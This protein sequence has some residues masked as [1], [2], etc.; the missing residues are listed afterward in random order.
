M[1]VAN[2]EYGEDKFVVTFGGLRIE[3]A[4]WNMLGGYLADSGWTAS[5]IEAGIATSGTADSFLT[6]F[7]LARTR[8]AHQLCLADLAKLEYRAFLQADS[9]R[10]DE[11]YKEWRARML[12]HGPTF[13]FWDSV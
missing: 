1:D 10:E 8:H 13:K 3:M 4:L 12:H 11:S 5:L 9:L 6:A 2:I 7:H